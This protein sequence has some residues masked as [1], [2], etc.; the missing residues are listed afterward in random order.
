VG[1]YVPLKRQEGQIKRRPDGKRRPHKELKRLGSTKVK[2]V[3]DDMD[4]ALEREDIADKY[5]HRKHYILLNY[6]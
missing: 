6:L 2:I 4:V 1:T 5:S 3:L